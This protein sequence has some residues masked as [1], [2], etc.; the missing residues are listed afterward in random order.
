MITY[1]LICSTLCVLLVQ[2]LKGLKKEENVSKLE[3]DDHDSHYK[4]I[5]RK[6]SKRRSLSRARNSEI[7]YKW[8]ELSKVRFPNCLLVCGCNLFIRAWST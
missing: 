5:V 1:I 3:R 4:P 6:F 2:S 7:E 8:K